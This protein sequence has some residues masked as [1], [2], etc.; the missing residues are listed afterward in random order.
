MAITMVMMMRDM[1]IQLELT[2]VPK[3]ALIFQF[4]RQI[5]RFYGYVSVFDERFDYTVF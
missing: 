2:N 1:N 4:R 5:S 3:I